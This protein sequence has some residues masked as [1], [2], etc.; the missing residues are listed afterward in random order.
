MNAPNATVKMIERVSFMLRVFYHD[1]RERGRQNMN[2][3]SVWVLDLV[4]RSLESPG[5]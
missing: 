2:N 5:A 1:E 3:G 4:T